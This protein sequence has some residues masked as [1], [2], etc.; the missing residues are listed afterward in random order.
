MYLIC[1]I[2]RI[3]IT[4]TLIVLHRCQEATEVTAKVNEVRE[5][6][7]AGLPG[8]RAQDLLCLTAITFPEKS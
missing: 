1:Y 8:P 6:N 5:A 2:G 3:G 7:V 4:E